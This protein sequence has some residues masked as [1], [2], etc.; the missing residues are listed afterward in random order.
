MAEERAMAEMSLRQ[1]PDD[2][3]PAAH[4]GGRPSAWVP[5][6][7]GSVPDAMVPTAGP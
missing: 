2:P 6:R 5:R 3:R 1:G 4:K 7:Q